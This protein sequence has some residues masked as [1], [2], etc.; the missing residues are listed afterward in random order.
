MLSRHGVMR[1]HLRPLLP[2][3]IHVSLS[4]Y[5]LSNTHCRGC[6][7]RDFRR[8]CVHLG[9]SFNIPIWLAHILVSCCQ[10]IISCCC[11]HRPP[12]LARP[13]ALV[14][15]FHASS[16]IGFQDVFRRGTNDHYCRP[17]C[18]YGISHSDYLWRKRKDLIF[19]SSIGKCLDGAT[20][21]SFWVYTSLPRPIS[22]KLPRIWG[23]R[24][25]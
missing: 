16:R 8:L 3:H 13:N 24:L 5:S 17:R 25:P 6:D 11:R 4:L 18:M 14:R 1:W 20:W 22:A 7:V 2:M 12:G 15:L 19:R 21:T 9:T 23:G 10:F